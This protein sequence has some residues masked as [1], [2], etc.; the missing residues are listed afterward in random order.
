MSGVTGSSGP[1][2]VLRAIFAELN[3]HQYTRPLYLSRR[4]IKVKVCRES[5]MLSMDGCSAYDEWFVP[6]TEP[7]ASDARDEPEEIYHLR[8]PTPGLHLAM[9]PRIPD[10]HEAFSFELASKPPGA[11]V[12][13]YVDGELMATTSTA[14]YLWP[15]QRGE[16]CVQAAVLPRYQNQPIRTPRIDFEVK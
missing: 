10:D 2:L 13:W 15:L 14:H 1:A 7:I 6:G 16:H 8:R 4:L 12:Q 9:D 5:G 11:A 3:R